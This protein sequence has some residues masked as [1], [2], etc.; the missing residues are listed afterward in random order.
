MEFFTGE[1]RQAAHQCL[2]DH[3]C[4]HEPEHCV[5]RMNSRPMGGVL[6]VDAPLDQ[7]CNYRMSFGHG[8]V[9]RCPARLA[10]VQELG[11]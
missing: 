8:T 4:A 7:C 5:C 1:L 9:C 10:I 2:K 3:R 11:F 6:F